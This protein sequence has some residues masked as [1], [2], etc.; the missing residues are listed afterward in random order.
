MGLLSIQ[1][2]LINFIVAG[3]ITAIIYFSNK[4]VRYFNPLLLFIISSI[5][6]FLGT[7]LAM[8]IPQMTFNSESLFIKNIITTIPGILLAFLFIYIWI[9]GS[10]SEGYV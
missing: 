7:S 4:K 6:T 8:L 3:L 9:K 5:G 1:I 2:L 10:K